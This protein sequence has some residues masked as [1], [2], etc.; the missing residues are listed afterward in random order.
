MAGGAAR[1]L[2]RSD[3]PAGVGRPLSPAPPFAYTLR[4]HVYLESYL[5]AHASTVVAAIAGFLVMVGFGGPGRTSQSTLA[6]LLGVTFMPFVA[7]P[8]FL[9]FGRRKFP[10]SVKTPEDD[11][12]RRAGITDEGTKKSTIARVLA[13]CGV[14]PPREGN[15]FELLVTG[16]TAYSRLLELV[17]GA[18]RT[19]DL[20]MFILGRDTTGMAVVDALVE[21]AAK[22]VSVRVIL[23]A[24]G[25]ARSRRHASAALAKVGGEVRSFMPFWHS[26]VRGRTNLRSHRKLMVVDGEHV[27]AGGMNLA[28]EYMGPPLPVPAGQARWRDV[29]AVTSGPVAVDATAMFESDWAY[30]GGSARKTSGAR[31]EAARTH[32]DAIAQLVP[33]GPELLT[34]T[35]YDLFLTGIFEAKERVSLVTPYY[36]PDDA[37][38]HAL[39]LAAHRGV[40]TEVVVPSVSNHRIADVARRSLLRALSAEGVRVLYYPRGMVHAKAMAIDASFAYVGSPNFDMRSLFLNYENA[41]CVY[42][43]EAVG[44]IR[45]FIESLMAEC[46]TEGPPVREHRLLEQLA[47]FLA[48]EL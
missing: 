17:R 20:T 12:E 39:V 11:A 46:V 6:W 5:L 18:E 35:V 27:F 47:R 16:E 1:D 41:L 38:Q 29:A 24:V 19:I 43:P 45:G 22:G 23:D 21:R 7:I 2:A 34:D 37:L 8:L 44:A 48:P 4:V 9:V 36:V 3:V 26:P 42:S 13:S 31:P 40:V 28:T 32:G 10:E 25:S 33:S 15:S 30:C 14:A